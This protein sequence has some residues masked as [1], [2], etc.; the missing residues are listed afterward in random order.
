MA[1]LLMP[2]FLLDEMFSHTSRQTSLSVARA[3]EVTCAT[4]SSVK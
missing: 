3:W 4:C 1:T 2:E